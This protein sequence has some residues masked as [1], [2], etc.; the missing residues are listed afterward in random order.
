M[1][2]F[3]QH[4]RIIFRLEFIPNQYG[5]EIIIHILR[6]NSLLAYEKQQMDKLSQQALNLAQKLEKTLKKMNLCFSS[7]R[8]DN[9]RDLRLVQQK[10]DR[11]LESLDK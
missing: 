5:E 2:R 3:H 9:M 6:G 1:E 8:L 11:H 10:I 4:E 7:T